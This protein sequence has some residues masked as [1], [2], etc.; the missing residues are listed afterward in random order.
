MKQRICKKESVIKGIESSEQKKGDETKDMQIA[1]EKKE[2]KDKGSENLD[3][4]KGVATQSKDTKIATEKC[5]DQKGNNKP[6]DLKIV[7]SGEK[8]CVSFE[9]EIVKKTDNSCDPS[10]P[11]SKDSSVSPQVVICA[12]GSGLSKY[13]MKKES[14]TDEYEEYDEMDDDGDSI[15]CSQMRDV[16]HM[17]Q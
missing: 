12:S 6:L 14:D 17:L 2:N 16:P 1:T 5:K 9:N 3:A 11:E 4:T 10:P 8:K 13:F 7:K 15:P